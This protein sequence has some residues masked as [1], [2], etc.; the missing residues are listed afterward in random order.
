MQ[1]EVEHHMNDRIFR[2]ENLRRSRDVTRA[3]TALLVAHVHNAY[4]DS[5]LQDR[6]PGDNDAAMVLKAASVPAAMT[7]GNWAAA[8][9]Q[10]SALDFV[11]SLAPIAASATLLK[12]SGIQFTFDGNGSIAIAHLLANTSNAGFSAEGLPIAF[13]D[14]SFDGP[15]LTPHKLTSLTGFTREAL[16]HSTPNIETMVRTMLAESAALTLDTVLFDANVGDTTRPNGLRYG[17]SA[18]SGNSTNPTKKEAMF[19]DLALLLGAIASVAGNGPVVIVA[20]PVKAMFLRLWSAPNAPYKVLASPA[21]LNGEVIAIAANALVS[22]LGAMPRFNVSN[23]ATLH[24][25]DTSP[26]AISAVATPNTV[27]APIR[28]LWQTDTIAL[29]MILD[30]AWG[31]RTAAGLAWLDDVTAW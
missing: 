7:A 30:V 16:Q 19:E 4:P 1:P 31:L 9:Q 22:S 23:Q 2:S 21:L 8:L 20:D 5:I 17:I 29:R 18:T 28:S 13:Q 26:A 15:V 27:A 6:W 24:M 12:S 14:F 10:A 25:E 3:A 11:Y